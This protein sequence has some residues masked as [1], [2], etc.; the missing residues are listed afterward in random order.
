METQK[1]AILSGI[2]PSGSLALGNYIGAM[3][4]WLKMLEEYNC[5]FMVVDLHALTV[6]QDPKELR[7]RCLSYVMQYLAAGLDPDKCTLFLQSHVPAHSQLSWVLSCFTYLGE[8]NRMTQFK[9]KS[10]KHQANINSGLFTYPVLMAA[11]ILLYQAKCV[12]V[13]EDQKQHLELTRDVAIRFNNYYSSETF[14]VPQPYIPEVGARIMSLQNPLQKMSKS[15]ESPNSYIAILDPPAVIRKKF[16][17]AVTDSET[18][19]RYDPEK[20]PGVSNL[21]TILSVLT[22]EDIEKVASSFAGKGYGPLKD[23]VADV[24]ITTLE[25]VQEKYKDLENNKDYVMEV[26]NKGAERAR[27]VAHK[28]L[29]KVY[30]KIGL[31]EAKY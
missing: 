23:R 22:G 16:R 21:L 14:T 11:D 29:R 24:V 5:Y 28:T 2:Q 25:G 15:D 17:R 12:P 8:L 26:V 19:V 4:N 31:V 6:S 3:K 30:K 27:K 7:K 10:S 1:P 20:K 18:E 9:E 13:G